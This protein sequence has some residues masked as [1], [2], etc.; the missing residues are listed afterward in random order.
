[1]TPN[2]VDVSV[3]DLNAEAFSPFG[4]LFSSG[5]PS[6]AFA[7]KPNRMI[8]LGFSVDGAPALYL[9]RYLASEMVLT[10]F[11]RHLAMTEARIA[12]GTAT[13]V[14]VVAA[15]N[16]VEATDVLPDVESVRA[17]LIRP[18]TGLVLKRSTWHA[19][20]C[21]PVHEPLVDFAFVSERESEKEL[22]GPVD[23]LERTQIVD[24]SDSGIEFRVS[25]PSGLLNS[26]SPDDRL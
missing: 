21:F 11:E 12:L 7:G 9:I 26:N 1:M 19:L 16:P 24:F 15:P 25:D 6:D 23:A 10:E 5:W 2:T 13:S 14:L 4:T 3:E 20:D 8:D 22:E 18:G 17:F